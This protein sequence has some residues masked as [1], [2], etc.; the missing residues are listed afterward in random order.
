MSNKPN[1]KDF[2]LKDENKE[3][4]KQ[5]IIERKNVTTEFT[6]ALVE[7]HQ[8]DLLK[9]KKELES[10]S[11]VCKATCDNIERNH[12]WIKDLDDEKLH[13]AWMYQENKTVVDKAEAKLKVV[14]EQLESYD[15]L[16]DTVYKKFGFVKS[17][18]IEED[19]DKSPES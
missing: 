9:L 19:N 2:E 10:Q 6:L 12:E 4:F 3:D 16:I 15:D 7:D 18:V 8:N 1:P 13:H 14:D 11:R 5:S 17:E